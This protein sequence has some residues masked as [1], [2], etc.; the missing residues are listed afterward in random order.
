MKAAVYHGPKDVRIESVP[1]P[2]APEDGELLVEVVLAAICGTDAGE[3]AHGPQ[4]VNL[5]GQHPASGHEGPVVL[6]HEFVGRVSGL[7]GGVQDFEVGERVVCG[8]GVSC[9]LCDWCKSGRTNLCEH[10]YTL[11]LHANGGLSEAV[12]TPANICVAVPEECSD[13]AAAMA[14]PLAVALHALNRGKAREG[15]TVAVLGAGGIGAFV[16][17]GA[18]ARGLRGLIAIDVAE[19]RLRTAGDLG[20]EHLVDARKEDPV[21]TVKQLTGGEGAH[22][23]IE[24]SGAAQAPGQ[25]LKMARR[26]G[27][28]AIVGLQSAPRE[29]DLFD[30]TTREVEMSSAL[31][32]VC[33]EDLP[34]AVAILTRTDL[35][36]KVADRVIGLDRLVPDGLVTLADG[37]ARGK[38][39]VDPRR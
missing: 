18:R 14:Q 24:A 7:G 26:G 32:H 35:A 10:Y 37:H 34:E 30:M 4:L 13:D 5:D 12:R 16:V 23:V 25:A 29:M 15:Q 8:A 17:G 38:I 1:E 22:V 39:L 2:S 9:G 19:D 20:A 21:E 33:A 36:S 28:V 3:Y 27:R 31:A 6:G 11:G